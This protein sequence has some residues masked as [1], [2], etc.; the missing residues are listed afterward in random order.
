M[1]RLMFWTPRIICIAFAA[2]LAIF[3]LDVFSMPGGFWYKALALFV[4]LIPAGMVLIVLAI[5]WRR[6]WI[7]AVFFPL[8]AIVHLVTKWGQ[9]HWSAYV[10]IDGPLLLLGILFL[11]NWRKRAVLRPNME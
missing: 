10:V 4:H 6:E 8:L 11:V 7:G 3:A 9:L 2:F 5:A 1:K